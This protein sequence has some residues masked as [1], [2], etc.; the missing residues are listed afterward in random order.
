MPTRSVAGDAKERHTKLQLAHALN[1]ILARR[2]LTQAAA[3]ELLGITQPKVS[4][5]ANDK[6]EGFSVE[7]LM[8][9]LTALDRDIEIVIRRKS[10]SRPAARIRVVAA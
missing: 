1:Q 9:F 6:L 10:R 2:R 7:R 8:T 3:A 4:A 5:L